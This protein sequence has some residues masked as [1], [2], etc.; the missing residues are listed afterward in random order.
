FIVR[1]MRITIFLT[2]ACVVNVYATGYSQDK[3]TLSLKDVKLSEVFKIIQE[4]THYQF[5]YNDE[6]VRNAPP[7]SVMVRGATV[8]QILAICFTK[9]YPLEYRIKDSTVVILPKSQLPRDIKKSR[10]TKV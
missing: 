8:P 3:L 4:D 7:V 5:L 10:E 1:A 2:L 6:D 9:D